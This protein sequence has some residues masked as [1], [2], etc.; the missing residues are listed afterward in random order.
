MTSRPAAE[1]TRKSLCVGTSS[2]ATRCNRRSRRPRGSPPCCIVVGG[3]VEKLLGEEWVA[4]RAGHDRLRERRRRGRIRASREQRRQLLGGEW[5]EL[6]Q[7]GGAR[8]LHAVCESTHV[9]ARGKLA[10]TVGREHQDRAVGEV[11]GEENDE[12]ERRAIRPVQVFE[13][14]Q[15]GRDH[16][17]LAEQRKRLL[18]NAQL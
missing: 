11:V 15:H 12:I 5:A 1:A 9:L 6:D 16:C 18:E 3:S 2:R 4:F 10:C 7:D 14:E 17:A 13:H 8:V